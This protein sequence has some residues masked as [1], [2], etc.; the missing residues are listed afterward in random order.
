M[1]KQFGERFM[2]ILRFLILFVLIPA[3]ALPRLKDIAK[4][5]GVRGN[6][7]VGYGL[8]VGLNGTGD[9]GSSFFT[10]K[11]VSNML[12]AFGIKVDPKQIKVKNSA[13]VVVTADLPP[14]AGIGTTLD[15]VVSSV[16]DAKSLQGGTLVLTPLRAADGQIYAVAQGALTVGG[17][18]FQTSQGDSVVQNHPTVGYISNGAIVERA[19]NFDITQ[20]QAIRVYL[21]K[22]DFTTA[23][24]VQKL[25]ND[26]FGKEVATAFDSGTIDVDLAKA[27][28]NSRQEFVGLV[29]R[30][31]N[32]P[33]E[34]G[35]SAV[36]L[37]NEKTGTVIISED[38][39]VS[40]VAV[41][42][43]NLSVIVKS[44]NTVS[45]PNPLGQGET[46]LVEN[47]ELTT[48]EESRTLN[49]LG[50]DVPLSELV[51][52]LNALGVTPRDLVSIFTAL[53]KAG[54]LN[55]ELV[56]M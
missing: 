7:L 10:T 6:Q 54:A 52:G 31:E 41:A 43:G 22:P 55:A 27:G 34:T 29:S 2:A 36:V 49:E 23:N 44:T 26:L 32:L 15:V 56:V 30:L 14:F 53:K 51:R 46:Q 47:T 39:K 13:A 1:A 8:V 11:S 37:V 12:E 38:V 40:K 35:K 17:Y 50:G 33:V 21:N 18:N 16:G 24:Y 20:R 5:E 25:V 48:A 42:H 45:Q 9:G 4:I 3:F 19:V 28:I